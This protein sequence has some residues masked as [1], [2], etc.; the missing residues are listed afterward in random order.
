MESPVLKRLLKE[1]TN[2]NIS[3]DDQ[4][5]LFKYLNEEANLKEAA[6]LLTDEWEQTGAERTMD[7]KVSAK[8]FDHIITT[9]VTI[10]KRRNY[11][12]IGYAAIAL[13]TL[14]GAIYFLNL[15]PDKH[16][17]VQSVVK[18][19]IKEDHEK[20][21]LPD[22]STVILNSN[23]R[24]TYAKYFTGLTREVT[25]SGEGYFDIKHNAGKP[26]IVHAGKLSTTVL[27]TAFNI[28]TVN[29]ENTIVVTVTRGKV[30]VSKSNKLLGILTPNQQLTYGETLP[31]PKV[32]KVKAQKVIDWQSKDIF[33]KDVT[34]QVAMDELS[35]R[36]DIKIVFA[37]D[38]GKD[39]RLTAT[40]LKGESLEEIL[41][42]IAAFNG[43]EFKSSGGE[44]TISGKSCKN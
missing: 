21:L 17:E 42:V 32:V 34:M 5:L 9:P 4:K 11:N 20:I 23:S 16:I 14:M 12:W 6:Q 36:F 41:N 33:F 37:D 1:Y 15:I 10:R 38:T 13:V 27:G 30:S 8:I 26:F 35:K 29:H 22:G 2:N 44:I 31:L 3:T 25:L 19:Q 7:E 43:A 40:F 39:C 24:L 18:M 28:R